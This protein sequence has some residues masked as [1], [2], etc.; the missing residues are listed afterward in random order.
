MAGNTSP[1][2]DFAAL[3]ANAIALVKGMGR[4]T[5]ATLLRA[6]EATPVDPAKPWRVGTGTIKEFKF[7]AVVSD[8]A[9]SRLGEPVFD[10]DKN[11]IIPG[12]I[13]TTA[14]EGDPG[15]LC[16]DISDR[17][18]VDLDGTQYQITGL[19]EIKPYDQPIIFIAR[20]KVWPSIMS[21]PPTQS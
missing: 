6:V 8:V 13:I 11:C 21:V 18:R 19:N 12:D 9:F 2:M 16:G 20:L 1:L 5:A 3:R 14:A 17:D 4:Q 10:G 15:T 7:T